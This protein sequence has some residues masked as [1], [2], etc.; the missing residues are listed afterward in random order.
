MATVTVAQLVQFAILAHLLSVSD[1]G[2]IA[3]V[4]V[5]VNFGQT[6]TSLGLSN[7]IIA[8]HI[9]D[10][11]TLSSIYWMSVGAGAFVALMALVAAPVLS[12]FYDEP[13]LLGLIAWSSLVFALSAPGQQFQ[14]L[15]RRDLNF[16]AV[17]SADILAVLPG[18]GVAIGAAA[19]GAGPVSFV[20]GV[21]V[22]SGVRTVILMA[23]CWGR[24]R[25]LLRFRYSE[26]RD[27][28]GF[29]AYQMG[30]GLMTFL[31]TNVDYLIIG[32]LIGTEALGAYTLAYQL[33]IQPVRKINPILT[34]VA[35][36]AF[37]LRHEDD[38]ALSRGFLELSK[39]LAFLA[40]PVL[41]GMAVLAPVL[42]P[43]IF[44][45]GWDAAVALLV[46]LSI[47]G[48][49]MSIGNPIGSIFL[50]KNRPDLGFKLN[51]AR[52]VLLAAVL[53]PAAVTG[54][55]LAVAWSYVGAILVIFPITRLI[56]QRLIG[57]RWSEY[58]RTLAMPLGL[59]A[60]AAVVALISVLALEREL[61]SDAAVLVGSA[62]A[63]A[64]AFTTL[65][66]RFQREYVLELLQMAFDRRTSVRAT[67]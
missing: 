43:T 61:G 29:A 63:G 25:P 22:T 23:R 3:L 54:N 44:G 12:S 19:L 20:W 55:V 45:S 48:G 38:A 66:W 7:V 67:E 24:W 21:I 37:A 56:I 11:E 42:V 2:L 30:E 41:A 28:L 13:E 10:P 62:A 27:S 1:F 50:A 65:A 46:P 17:A 49:F 53:T 35:F 47:V 60:G 51:A 14:I 16:H 40:F 59:A 15:L 39:L 18:A 58:L 33:V 8:R 9:R 32:R 31:A 64:V 52:F 57:L 36:P 26:V 5:V 6:F 34:I 4:L